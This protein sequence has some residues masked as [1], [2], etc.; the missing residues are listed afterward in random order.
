VS[1]ELT[2]TLTEASDGT[3][4]PPPA[5]SASDESGGVPIWVWIGGAVI[6]LA[7]GLVFAL[8][9]GGKPNQ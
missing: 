5:D 1:G 7:A 3:P 9:I 2:F 6:V 4:A 8:R